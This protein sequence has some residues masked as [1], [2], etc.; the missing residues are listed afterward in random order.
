[1]TLNPQQLDNKTKQPTQITPT[2]N[3]DL[4]YAIINGETALPS[5]ARF[6][7]NKLVYIRGLRYKEQLEIAQIDTNLSDPEIAYHSAIRVY[8]NCIKLEGL[9]FEDLLEE[10]FSTL[11]LWIVFLTNPEQT[12]QLGFKCKE[13]GE[14]NKQDISPSQIE[15]VDFRLFE[16][17]LVQTELG[18]LQIAPITM[19]EN[20]WGQTLDSLG[21]NEELIL[22]K[23][24]KAI[25]GDL[26]GDLAS[27]MEV[28]GSLALSDVKAVRNT[29]L[30]FK[31]GVKSVACKC[32][33]CGNEQSVTPV[34]DILRGLP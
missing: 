5:K 29:A 3:V 9:E 8:K 13:C 32:K 4:E 23:H 17:Q 12:Y 25:N 24:I 18:A 33:S 1:M 34:L 22:G 30:G 21:I 16:T 11:A 20:L 7:R 10:D 15:L 27:R 26:L 14:S 6:Y 19:R 28:Y 2:L 31:S